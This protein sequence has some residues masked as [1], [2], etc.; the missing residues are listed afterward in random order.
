MWL[1]HLHL[2]SSWKA[3][4]FLSA[5]VTAVVKLDWD[6]RVLKKKK[7]KKTNN[8]KSRLSSSSCITEHRG[9]Y[10]CNRDQSPTIPGI[11]A[12]LRAKLTEIREDRFLSGRRIYK[13]CRNYKNKKQL[14][15]HNACPQDERSWTC[16]LAD[17]K[18][19]LVVPTSLS[20]SIPIWLVVLMIR[21]CFAPAS[22]STVISSRREEN[23]MI[24]QPD[25]RTPPD[26][27]HATNQSVIR[28]T[29]YQSAQSERMRTARRRR[30]SKVR[31]T[32]WENFQSTPANCFRPR[33]I[34]TA[35]GW[36]SQTSPC[37]YVL[38]F[39]FYYSLF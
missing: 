33:N 34:H 16:N 39:N 31:L 10:N 4:A 27:P 20:V 29:L 14:N 23:L 8:K 19:V 6:Q 17:W 1:G 30:N 22:R 11:P 13:H 25:W 18:D 37:W 15:T 2:P 32:L 24:V 12:N 9:G 36:M 7:K 21:Y 35:P 28:Q 3:Y 38:L 26:E 5:W